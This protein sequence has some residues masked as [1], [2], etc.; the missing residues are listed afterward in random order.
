MHAVLGRTAR[1]KTE[2]EK[3][4]RAFKSQLPAGLDEPAKNPKDEIHRA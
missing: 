3:A 4:T 2:F 1:A